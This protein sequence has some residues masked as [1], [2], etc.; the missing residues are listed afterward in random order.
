MVSHTPMCVCSTGYT[1]DPF[2][3]CYEFDQRETL[4]ILLKIVDEVWK[5][6]ADLILLWG[7]SVSR[8]KIILFIS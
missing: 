3:Q 2:T 5:G 4:S 8:I 6:L 1:G 7:S